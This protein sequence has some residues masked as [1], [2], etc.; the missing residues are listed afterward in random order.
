MRSSTG[1]GH[2]HPLA[3]EAGS[4]TEAPPGATQG[5][6]WRRIFP[7]D[8]RELGMLRRWLAMLL[9][10]CPA[11]D[12]VTAVANELASNAIRH[13]L[14]GRGG[15]FAV[16]VTWFSTVVRIAVADRGAPS[17]PRLVD[18]PD[19]ESGRGLVLVRGLSLHTGMSGD[20]RGRLVWA[21]V[22]WDDPGGA[23]Q[24]PVGHEAA[25]RDGQAALAARFAGVSAWFGRTTLAWWALAGPDALVSAPTALELAGLL[26]RLR[27]RPATSSS[28]ESSPRPD[29]AT[30]H[31]AAHAPSGGGRRPARLGAPPPPP[32]PGA[33]HDPGSPQG[34]SGEASGWGR[35]R[36]RP[37]ASGPPSAPALVARVRAGAVRYEN[38]PAWRE[39]DSCRTDGWWRV[40]PMLC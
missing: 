20:Q 23:E 12:D 25:V 37:D 38:A 17:G 21:D 29:T 10:E 40:S 7:G 33:G 31:G 18:N 8:E 35:R 24:E 36:A 14:S 13:T 22:R 27:N 2:S 39:R 6:R 3:D 19:A 1:S 11:R 15:Y 16:E 26:S 4:R 5:L 28:T 32:P 34:G 30:G 9:P